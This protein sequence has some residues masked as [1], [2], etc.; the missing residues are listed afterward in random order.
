MKLIESSDLDKFPEVATFVLDTRRFTVKGPRAT[1]VHDFHY[2]M[3]SVY[4]HF[5]INM[6][7][8][9]GNSIVEVRSGYA[10][11]EEERISF[12]E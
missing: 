9:D 10:I 7:L 1:L 4:A 8:Q 3:R 6:S 11:E 12:E 2:K 5:P